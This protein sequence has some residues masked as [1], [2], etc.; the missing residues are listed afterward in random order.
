MTR[1]EREEKERQNLEENLLLDCPPETE[2][3]KI[4]RVYLYMPKTKSQY[5]MAFIQQPIES[6]LTVDSH[7]VHGAQKT[8][9]PQ[10]SVVPIPVLLLNPGPSR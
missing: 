7:H 2:K 9:S 8:A 6:Q 4:S 3:Y 10:H 1:E 5:L